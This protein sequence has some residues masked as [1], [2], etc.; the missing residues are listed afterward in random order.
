[1]TGW[2]ASRIP[3]IAP[4]ERPLAF[5]SLKG[6]SF[7]M[8]VPS[9]SEFNCDPEQFDRYGYVVMPEFIGSDELPALQHVIDA[10]P[11]RA[12]AGN[13]WF[14]NERAL[15]QTERFAQLITQP[16]TVA[17]M[18]RLLGDD[19]QLLDYAVM[20][21]PPD[22]GKFRSWHADFHDSFPF[23]E[24]PPLMLTMLV[25]LDDMTQERGPLYVR[26]GTHKLQRHPDRQ[27]AGVS[28]AEEIAL[29]VPGGTAVAFHSNLWH[30]GSPN[31]TSQPRRLLFSLW[32]H[33]WMKRLD[34]YYS[35]PLPEYILNSPDPIVRQ[36]FGVQ[37]MAPSVHG[38]DYNELS[39]S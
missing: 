3:A 21:D 25:Y 19:L 23:V 31:A 5:A 37:S 9:V 34:E 6:A 16:R 38:N 7:P 2:R 30:S 1:V 39:Y 29:A 22:T 36:L 10:L 28:S 11:K 17:M 18:R 35:T 20:E 15:V 13:R 4:R 8:T 14:V 26:P 27:E 24:S 12:L 32:G 33:Y